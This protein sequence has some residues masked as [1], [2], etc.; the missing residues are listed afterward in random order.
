MSARPDEIPG[1]MPG[2]CLLHAYVSVFPSHL[3]PLQ[4]GRVLPITRVSSILHPRGVPRSYEPPPPQDP[5]V[6]LC[7]ETCGDP[8]GVGVSYG[9]A[10][11]GRSR[12]TYVKSL[13]SSYTGLYLQ[14]T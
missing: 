14:R 3:Q 6:A 12:H 8:V 10:P 7:L 9:R 5:T 1:R 13:R 4:D 2:A 11:L